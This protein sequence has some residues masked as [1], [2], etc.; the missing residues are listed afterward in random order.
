MKK[1]IYTIIFFIGSFFVG[2]NVGSAQ[3]S[4]SFINDD[5]IYEICCSTQTIGQNISQCSAYLAGPRCASITDRNSYE[6]CCDVT[7]P[8]INRNACLNYQEKSNTNSP[9]NCSMITNDS[10]YSKCCFPA[11]LDNELKCR[12]YISKGVNLP[13]AGVTPPAGGSGGVTSSNTSNFSNSDK[14]QQCT[15]IKFISL[16]NI[17]IWTKCVINSFVIPLIFTLAFTFF[18]W[19]IFQFI[20]SSDNKTAKD[21][22]KQRLVWGIVALFVMVSVWGIVTII[23]NVFD[24][25]P[26]VPML[27]TE[28]LNPERADN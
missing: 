15:D 10:D 11:T 12:E 24:I 14:A 4:C 28:Y 6:L 13:G 21:D 2:F 18:L 5:T 9:Q 23:T 8:A 22:A 17:L 7:S 19:N 27:Q 26:T 16:L 20:R 1:I 3:D 25:Q